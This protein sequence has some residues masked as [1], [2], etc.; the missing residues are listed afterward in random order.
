[1]DTF[2]MVVQCFSISLILTVLFLVIYIP[3]TLMSK[4]K[5]IDRAIMIY[6]FTTTI[7]AYKR[8]CYV[9][10][11][12]WSEELVNQKEIFIVCLIACSFF[13]FI[14]LPELSSRYTADNSSTRDEIFKRFFMSFI[15]M[16]RNAFIYI[17]IEHF[18]PVNLVDLRMKGD[19]HDHAFAVSLVFLDVLERGL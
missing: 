19:M 13:I 4:G 2:G 14:L 15:P 10:H 3:V 18:T 12:E 9:Y 7:G 8:T 5:T 17:L 1:M 16:V 6:H 11:P